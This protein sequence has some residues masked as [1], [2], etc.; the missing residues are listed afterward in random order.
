MASSIRQTA[1][2]RTRTQQSNGQW[3]DYW[4]VVVTVSGGDLENAVSRKL[5]V[6]AN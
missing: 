5:I 1:L 4:T 2:T 6:A 3:L